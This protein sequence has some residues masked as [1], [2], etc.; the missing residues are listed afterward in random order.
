ML[1]RKQTL[2]L[3]AAAFLMAFVLL[4]PFVQNENFIF[5]AFKFE[6]FETNKIIAVYPIGIFVII[7]IVLNLFTLMLFKNR[8]IQ[9]RFTIFCLLFSIG[10]Y[11]LLFF[12]HYLISQI[13]EIKITFYNFTLLAPFMAAVFDYMA[14]GGIKRDE[15]II[16]DSERLR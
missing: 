3:L 11:G 2:Y 9:M 7:A 1:Q 8:R 14:Y 5:S 4:N 6:N 15:K 13:T 12:Y 10:F 16:K